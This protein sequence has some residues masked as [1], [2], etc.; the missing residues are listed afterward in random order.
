MTD[1]IVVLVTCGN[2]GEAEK[3]AG[4]LVEQKLVAC[5]NLVP[6]IESWYWW[7][8][9]VNREAE[10]LLVMKT[11]QE[12]FAL[13]ETAIQGLHSYSV[14]EIIALPICAGSREYL[15]WIG[16]SVGRGS[17]DTPPPASPENLS[18]GNI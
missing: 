14:P 6:G 15:Q 13:L 12:N 1:K 18:S 8:G 5:V 3:L 7:E 11:T 17:K 9:K 2:R 16:E 4:E 10:L